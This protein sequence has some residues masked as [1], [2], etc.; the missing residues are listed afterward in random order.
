MDRLVA[1]GF[2][3]RGEG[4]QYRLNAEAFRALVPSGLRGVYHQAYSDRR[5][6]TAIYETART[7]LDI[8]SFVVP[9]ARAAMAARVAPRATVA[10]AH[11]I[12]TAVEDGS[13]AWTRTV[14]LLETQEG[15]TVAAAGVRDLT[16][17]Q[18][19]LAERMGHEVARSPGLHGETT[20][21]EHAA[22]EGLTPTHGVASARV[23]PTQCQPIIRALG[24]EVEGRHFWFPA[25][26]GTPPGAAASG[27]AGAAVGV[28]DVAAAA[29][30][31]V[32]AAVAH[33]D[34]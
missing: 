24:G 20:A 27:A 19:E 14:A 2:A 33:G 28:G 18:A 1:A 34:H 12:A 25:T 29:A 9:L 23:C 21:L 31:G 26:G 4:G 22:R 11:A 17:A 13:P 32:T 8:L 15:R 3:I 5:W 16:A 30:G 10:V 7:I 6:A